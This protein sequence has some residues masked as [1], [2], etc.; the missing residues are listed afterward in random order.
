MILDPDDCERFFKLHKALTLFVSQRL[1]VVKPLAV[2][3]RS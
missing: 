3:V 1:K 2:P